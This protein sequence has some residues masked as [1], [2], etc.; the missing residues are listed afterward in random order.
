MRLIDDERM[1]KRGGAT[2]HPIQR[3]IRQ[4]RLVVWIASANIGVIAGEPK[5]LESFIAQL[6]RAGRVEPGSP[7]GTRAKLARFSSIEMACFPYWT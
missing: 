3:D 1:G 6:I 2:D 4:S 7:H 5:L